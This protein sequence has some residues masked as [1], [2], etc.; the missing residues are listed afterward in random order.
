[1]PKL[2][3]YLQIKEPSCVLLISSRF[4]TYGKNRCMVFT[5]KMCEKHLWE[6]DIL[7]KDAGHGPASL[8][9]TL[10]Q[11][12]F[13]PFASKN[14]PPGFSI[15]GKLA[16]NGISSSSIEQQEIY[17]QKEGKDLQSLALTSLKSV[18]IER[19][20]FQHNNKTFFPRM[21]NRKLTEFSEQKFL[22]YNKICVED[23]KMVTRCNL[24]M[25]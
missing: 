3:L 9:K 10:S 19:Q 21:L 17:Y 25:K 7:S 8:L 6:S 15:M 22:L 2:I 1:M 24:C 13:K 18:Q 5:S 12:F 14:H 23:K 11:V 20:I 16:G 4:S